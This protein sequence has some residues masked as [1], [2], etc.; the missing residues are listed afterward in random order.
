[1]R[2][3]RTGEIGNEKPGV[4]TDDDHYVDVSDYVRDYDS[5]FFAGGVRQ[6]ESTVAE[7]VRAGSVHD[8]TGVRVGPP[9]ARPHQILC[10]GLNYRAHAAESGMQTTDEPIIFTKAPN[11]LS[12][13]FDPVKMPVGGEKLDYEVEL[14]VVI[15]SRCQY[16]PDHASAAQAIAGFVLVNDVSER[17]FQLERSGQ[18]LKGKSCE[19]FNPCGP[20]LVSPDELGSW[21]DLELW[22]DVN[23]SRRQTGSTSWMIFDVLTI[24][25]HL[26]QFMVLEPGDLINTGTPPGVASGMRPPVYLEVGDL[27]ELGITGLGKQRYEIAP[28]QR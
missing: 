9:I 10:V 14:G 7:R 17:A 1:M 25:H 16:L 12:G 6:L 20:V 11:S 23:G 18:W 13:P 2:L 27:L 15:G 28:P 24:I 19:T 4:M 26:S 8:L 3:V 5:E 21:D 22:L